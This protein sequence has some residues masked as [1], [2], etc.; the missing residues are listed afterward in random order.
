ML[1]LMPHFRIKEAADLLGVSDDTVRNWI[2]TGARQLPICGYKPR[3]YRGK[4]GA[5]PICKREDLRRMKENLTQS[6]TTRKKTK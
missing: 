5:V 2:K 3:K 1:S 4:P 6:P